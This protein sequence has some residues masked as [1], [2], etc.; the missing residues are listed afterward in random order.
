MPS[1]WG[2][3]LE[4]LLLGPALLLGLTVELDVLQGHVLPLPQDE[5]VDEGGQGLRVIGA[6]PPRHESAGLSS[7]RSSDRRGSPARSS[8]FSTLE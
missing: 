5:Q 7:G 8:M 1:I 2:G 6:G 3:L 4:E